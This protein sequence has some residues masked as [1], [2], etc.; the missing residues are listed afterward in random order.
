MFRK[1]P[2]GVGSMSHRQPIFKTSTVTIN[3]NVEAKVFEIYHLFTSI[4]HHAQTIMLELRRDKHLEY[5][6]KGLRQLGPSFCVLDAKCC[7]SEFS[8]SNE[9]VAGLARQMLTRLSLLRDPEGGYAGEPG[10]MAH[11][12]TTYAAVNS[13]ITLGS[14]RVLSTIN[15]DKMHTFLLR[16]KQPSGAFRMHDAGEIDVR[17]CYAAISLSDI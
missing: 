15:R 2:T 14:Q 13:V 6:T 3:K 7:F 9:V 1:I 5:L 11:L 12:A 8:I 16:L 17:A 4:Q 10:Q